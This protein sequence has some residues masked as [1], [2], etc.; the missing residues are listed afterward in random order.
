MTKDQ[1]IQAKAT[2]KTEIDKIEPIIKDAARF[3]QLPVESRQKMRR[4]MIARKARIAEIDRIEKAL[5]R[6]E[7]HDQAIN[8]NA[9]TADEMKA[10]EIGK[11]E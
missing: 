10:A 7:M 5:S 3:H 11:S 1:A 2:E 8:E 4:T 9:L 6:I